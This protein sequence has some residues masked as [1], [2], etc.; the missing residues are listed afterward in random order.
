[1][2]RRAR[3]P[4]QS[5]ESGD[6]SKFEVFGT[7]N[8]ELRTMDR[9]VLSSLPRHAPVRGAGALFQHPAR[10]RYPRDVSSFSPA[11]PVR[12]LTSSIAWQPVAPSVLLRLP[13]HQKF[14]HLARGFS[15]GALHAV[16]DS[17]GIRIANSW[18]LSPFDWRR[19]SW[20]KQQ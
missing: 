8:P 11:I 20:Q 7:S 15:L 9:T 17:C 1:M 6:G 10:R 5:R 16:R 12:I 2:R 14:T 3:D 4:S 19:I 13:C 18:F